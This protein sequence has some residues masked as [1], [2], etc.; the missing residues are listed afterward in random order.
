MTPHATDLTPHLKRGLAPLY[1]V[2]GDESLLVQ[3]MTDEL[4]A[5]TQELGYSERQVFTVMGAH[6]DW[7]SVFSEFQS[8][9]LFADKQLIELRIPS[10]KPGKEGGQAIEKLVSMVQTF[11]GPGQGADLPDKVLL[12]TLPRLDKL[13]KSSAWHQC[14]ES[15]SPIFVVQN[16]ERAALSNWIVQRLAAQDQ[17]V[18]AGEQGA[19]TLQFFVSCVEGNLLAAHQEIQKLALLYLPGELGFEQVQQAVLNVSRF[20][21]FKLSE[22]VLSGQVTR[23]QRML[24]GLQA[25]GEAAV[26]VHFAITED[27]RLLY[28]IKSSMLAGKALPMV[29]KEYRV[30]GAKE[31]LFER[32]I[33]HMP[34]HVLEKLLQ[35]CHR[36]DGVVKGLRAPNWPENPWM[37]LQQ[38]AFLCAKSCSLSK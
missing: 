26:L 1:V 21:V 25:E 19:Q 15:A 9:G 5:K 30:W 22:A 24:D 16:I 10:G 4:R 37:A 32:V 35:A 6:F 13:T 14:L 28:K 27:I 34:F 12:I 11:H 36:V 33:G 2:E 29:L 23:V 18:T 3:E 7:T 31:K 38:L 8:M 20:D 17:R